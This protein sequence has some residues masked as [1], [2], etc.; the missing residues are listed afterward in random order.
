MVL[1]VNQTRKINNFLDRTFTI[2]LSPFLGDSGDG[3]SVVTKA[4]KAAVEDA[5]G[6]AVKEWRRRKRMCADVTNAILESY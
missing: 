5:H 3:R 2:I 6:L 1:K 4:E